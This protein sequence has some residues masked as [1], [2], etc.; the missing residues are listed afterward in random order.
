MP[1][2]VGTARAPESKPG[3]ALRLE[4]LTKRFQ[5]V[6]AV[7]GI[8]LEIPSGSFVTLLGPSGS[9]KT[10][11]LNLIAGFLV[12]DAGEIFI[13]EQ[14]VSQV[15]THKRNIGMVFQN[16]ALF[17]HM[18][19]FENVAFP[20][21]MRSRLTGDELP[22]RVEATLDLVQLSGFEGRYP[23]QLSGGQQQ[24][25]AMARALVSNPRLLLMD[26][27][28]GA[29]DKKLRE[30]M[31]IEIKGIHRTVGTTFVYVTHDQSEA[32]AMSDLVVVMH[33]G[34]IAQVGNPR[35][36]YEAPESEFVA[37]FLGG[38]NVL[39]GTVKGKTADDLVVDVGGETIRVRA[40]SDAAP[41]GAP[42]RVLIRPEDIDVAPDAVGGPEVEGLAGT[43]SE[44]IY[45]G[46]ATRVVVSAKGGMLSAKLPGRR[47]AD[48]SPGQAVT[49]SW[50]RSAARVLRPE[51]AA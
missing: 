31:Q 40:G 19:V 45:L 9:G 46:D 3:A 27:P 1:E 17:P 7:D 5:S 39:G 43:V 34:R 13:D 37:D 14:P 16:Y 26:E 28:L 51:D 50:P 4:R 33:E 2:R 10:T 41:S 15:P 29:L 42:V 47:G 36:L 38:A 6:A 21:R 24:R 30:R 20:L 25:V 12:P 32:L 8:S 49:I 44:V 18:T 23:R 11:T 22:Q 35:R 48:L